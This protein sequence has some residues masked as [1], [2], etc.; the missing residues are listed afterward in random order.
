MSKILLVEDSDECRLVI[1]RAL[2]GTGIEVTEART[3]AEAYNALDQA[4]FDLA[5][6]DLG[7][8]DGNGMSFLEETQF[9]QIHVPI[10][11]LTGN[12][13]LEM[14]VTSFA[15]GVDDY[16]VKPANPVELKAR[17]MMRLKKA[18]SSAAGEG[19]KK[20]GNLQLN[21]SLLQAKIKNGTQEEVLELT[22]K[23]FRILSLLAAGAGKIFSRFELVEAIWGKSVHVLDRTVDSHVCSIRRK[24]GPQSSYLE[25]VPGSGYRFRSSPSPK[26][27]PR[28][29]A[30]PRPSHKF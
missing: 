17:V 21:L 22:N 11:F 5:L 30:G 20:I 18:N 19:W 12:A 15:M 27:P 14:K 10:F 28:D 16:I 24:L 25:S 6:V 9:R 23:E 8:P 2:K 4:A 7:L 1:T 3:L 13:D 26:L 29:P